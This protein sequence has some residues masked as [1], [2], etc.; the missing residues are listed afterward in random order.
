MYIMTVCTKGEN[1]DV[2]FLFK[3]HCVT[4]LGEFM[5]QYGNMHFPKL[6]MTITVVEGY[7]IDN[8]KIR[9]FP[10]NYTPFI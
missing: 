10:G 5:K 2:F 4:S 6:E 7:Q 1:T 3:F 9:D 8:K